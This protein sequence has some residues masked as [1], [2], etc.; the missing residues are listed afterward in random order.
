MLANLDASTPNCISIVFKIN[1]VSAH[2]V[3]RTSLRLQFFFF[4]LHFVDYCVW[5][6]TCLHKAALKLKDWSEE[7]NLLMLRKTIDDVCSKLVK[8]HDGIGWPTLDAP[9]HH[10]LKIGCIQL[11]TAVSG[12]KKPQDCCKMREPLNGFG[13]F[14][15]GAWQGQDLNTPMLL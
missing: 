15:C 12:F 3:T 1:T 6:S 13:E 14:L 7:H 9:S 4:T 5:P 8:W 10:P 2:R 11:R